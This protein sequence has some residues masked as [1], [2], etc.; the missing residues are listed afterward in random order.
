MAKR[1]EN[2]KIIEVQPK[3]KKSLR[4]VM[5]VLKPTLPI[6]VDEAIELAKTERAKV[7]QD[8]VGGVRKE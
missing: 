1:H 5:G 8:R 2:E 6:G 4:D 3:N 7:I